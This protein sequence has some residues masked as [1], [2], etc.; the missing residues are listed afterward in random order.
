MDKKPDDVVSVPCWALKFIL[1]HGCFQDD[2]PFPEG[3]SSPAMKH[4]LEAI[5]AAIKKDRP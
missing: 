1:D 4:A 2:G 3:W 5:D